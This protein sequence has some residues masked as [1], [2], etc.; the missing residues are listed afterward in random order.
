MKPCPGTPDIS[1]GG[2]N[3]STPVFVAEWDARA[4][5]HGPIDWEIDTSS[6]PPMPPSGHRPMPTSAPTSDLKTQNP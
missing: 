6:T 3:H 2:Q 5:F 1:Y 4:C